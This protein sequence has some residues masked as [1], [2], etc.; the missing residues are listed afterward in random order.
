MAS[1]A[2]LEAKKKRAE[3]MAALAA[4]PLARY[5]DDAAMNQ[6]LKET[7]HADDPMAE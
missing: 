1:T 7:I 5:S 4:A 6:R 3:E 2:T